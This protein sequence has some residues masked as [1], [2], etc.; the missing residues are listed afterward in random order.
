MFFGL[1]PGLSTGLFTD[2]SKRKEK[3]A[4]CPQCTLSK[5]CSP[6]VLFAV[7]IGIAYYVLS[8]NCVTCRGFCGVGDLIVKFPGQSDIQCLPYNYFRGGIIPIG[9]VSTICDSSNFLVTPYPP[10]ELFINNDVSVGK[11]IK[12]V[13]TLPPGVTNDLSDGWLVSWSELPGDLQRFNAFFYLGYFYSLKNNVQ[14]SSYESYPGGVSP[15]LI[16]PIQ[17][18]VK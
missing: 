5:C 9:G 10:L 8:S 6:L 11:T 3:S 2:P 15:C 13:P 16:D 14:N 7:I 18:S 17:C 1:F 12:C 4:E